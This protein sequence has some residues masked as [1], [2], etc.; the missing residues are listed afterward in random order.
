MLVVLFAC[1]ALQ[2]RGEA[3]RLA[4]MPLRGS[5][6]GRAG[7]ATGKG[8]GLVMEVFEGNPAGK[9]AWNSLWNMPFMRPG[10]QG[11]PCTFGDTARIFKGNIEQVMSKY[12]LPSRRALFRPF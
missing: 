11:E 8:K 3:F 6:A 5:P 12:M 1:A 9:W 7:R 4:G 2:W 10:K